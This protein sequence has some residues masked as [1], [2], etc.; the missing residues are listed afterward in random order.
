[1]AQTWTPPAPANWYRGFIQGKT[2]IVLAWV[3]AAILVFSARE[4]P[5]WPGILVCF[6]GASVR[7]WASGFLRK[8]QF[9]AVGGP[10]A[11][12]RNPLYLGTFLMALGTAWAIEHYTLVLACAVIFGGIYHFIILD[13]ETKLRV[14]FGAP[15]EQYK[16]AVNR[17]FPRL[18]PI[19]TATKTAINP[20]TS[21]H[22]FSWELAMKNKAY[23]AYA[24][25]AALIAFVAAVAWAWK[26]LA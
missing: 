5:T 25:F 17:F 24:S 21:H 10:Y 4:Y 13:E 11:L 19:G 9:P 8:D 22:R 23:E 26:T 15:Y 6:V 2:R 20:E 7:F 3:F 16:I 1:M 14:L 18:F 12:T